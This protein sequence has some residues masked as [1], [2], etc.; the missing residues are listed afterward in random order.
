M[1]I[2]TTVV[3]TARVKNANVDSVSNI[4]ERDNEA[5]IRMEDA[6]DIPKFNADGTVGSANNS[7]EGDDESEIRMA[8]TTLL[9]GGPKA[10]GSNIVGAC[11]ERNLLSLPRSRH[12]GQ[13]CETKV[14]KVTQ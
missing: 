4:R 10:I 13:E 5:E 6:E 7:E 9:V 11:P 2:C 8:D 12:S 14:I 1:S 3:L